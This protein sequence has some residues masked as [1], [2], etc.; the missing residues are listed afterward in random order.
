MEPLMVACVDWPTRDGVMG[1]NA[2][3]LGLIRLARIG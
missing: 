3:R 1:R 2:L